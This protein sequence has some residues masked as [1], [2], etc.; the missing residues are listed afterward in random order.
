[1]H[2]PSAILCVTSESKLFTCHRLQLHI[3]R[4][5][6]FSFLKIFVSYLYKNKVGP[7]RRTHLDRIGGHSESGYHWPQGP[8]AYYFFIYLVQTNFKVSKVTVQPRSKR[9][10]ME[11]WCVDPCYALS[12]RDECG[13]TR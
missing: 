2:T 3:Y 6:R 8:G 9:V 10:Q 4:L 7:H 13:L 5:T 12:K 1:M 11:Y